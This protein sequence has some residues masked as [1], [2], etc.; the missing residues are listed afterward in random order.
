MM[1]NHTTRDF[2]AAPA[3]LQNHPG[4]LFSQRAA[5]RCCC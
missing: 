3:T 1:T 4:A 5:R 2:Q